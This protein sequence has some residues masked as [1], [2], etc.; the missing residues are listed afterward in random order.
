M[1]ASGCDLSR[2]MQH[3]NSNSKEEDVEY[4]IQTEDLLHRRTEGT[5]VGSPGTR[6]FPGLNCAFNHLPR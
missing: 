6:R 1:T 3:L 2:S 5:D 4:E